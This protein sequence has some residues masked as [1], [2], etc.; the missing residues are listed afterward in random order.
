MQD[1]MFNLYGKGSMPIDYIY[2]LLNIDSEN[3]HE[4]LKRD[5][6]GPKDATFNEVLRSMY[7][8]IG[9]KLAEDSNATGKVAGNIGLTV[10]DK[11]GDRFGKE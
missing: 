3:A 7:P 6:F 1:F 9:E 11:E 10:S 2:D 4:L 8:K 5:M